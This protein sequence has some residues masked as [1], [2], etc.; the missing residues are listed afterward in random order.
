MCAAHRD[1]PLYS[2]QHCWECW[3]KDLDRR[4]PGAVHTLRRYQ[5]DW[6]PVNWELTNRAI[7]QLT[8]KSVQTVINARQ[9]H[10]PEHLRDSVT[11]K[12]KDTDWT[13][14]DLEIAQTMG[15]TEQGVQH[16]RQRLAP[17]TVRRIPRKF[18]K[19]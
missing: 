19:R 18:S 10:A 4:H 3:F 7:A 16:A 13:K 8:G 5:V 2:R 12:W 11:L 9:R 17:Q 6:K 15:Y 1:R 14:S